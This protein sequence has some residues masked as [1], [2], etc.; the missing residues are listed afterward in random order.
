MAAEEF[1][2]RKTLTATRLQQEFERRL[3]RL[4]HIADDGVKIRVPRPRMQ[5][6]D[7][8]GCN[9]TLGHFSNAAGYKK[10]IAAVLAAMRAEYNLAGEVVRPDDPFGT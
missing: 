10:D 8:S 6:P 9:W 5:P 1:M 4:D 2:I 3:H 7:A